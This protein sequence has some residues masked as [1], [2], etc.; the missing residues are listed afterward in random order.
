MKSV[1]LLWYNRVMKSV[2][3][4]FLV[5]LLNKTDTLLETDKYSHGLSFR[6]PISGVPPTRYYENILNILVTFA[7][8]LTF[9]LGILQ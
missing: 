7:L 3:G 5:F 4:C 1:L 6:I 8:T 9:E 2:C